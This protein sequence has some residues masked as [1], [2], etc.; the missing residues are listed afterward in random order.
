MNRPAQRRGR[1]H[2]EPHPAPAA[3]TRGS[4]CRGRPRN[5][6]STAWSSSHPLAAGAAEGGD[7]RRPPGRRGDRS[8]RA[9]ARHPDVVV[10]HVTD[11]APKAHRAARRNGHGTREDYLRR[12]PRGGRGRPR[13]R[14][15]PVRANP[16][17]RLRGREAALRLVEISYA[18]AG[19][20]D[21]L[22][23]ESCSPIRTRAGT[24]T[25]T[26]GFR[27]SLAC[28]VLRAR[29]VPAPVVLELTSYHTGGAP[30]ACGLPSIATV[31]TRR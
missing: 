31:P 29:G 18:V 22:R 26:H 28:G 11:G 10:A 21:E 19:F 27:G 23:P 16:L 24:R 3:V 5:S 4:R 25:T 8:R 20:L 15:I 30:R 7:R 13:S 2:A 14:R 6:C 12:A 1:P 9:H 17:P